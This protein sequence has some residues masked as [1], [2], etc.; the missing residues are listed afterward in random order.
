MPWIND[1]YYYTR[2]ILDAIVEWYCLLYDRQMKI[3]TYQITHLL[4]LVEF[5]ADF[6]IALDSIGRGKWRGLT[7][8]NFNNYGQFGRMQRVIIASILGITDYEL[9]AFGFSDAKQ[10]RYEGYKRMVGFLNE[11]KARI[12]P[13]PKS[14][15]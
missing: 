9:R 13:C 11:N 10:L 8:H 6:D 2:G 4:T 5:K 7:S 3:G 12:L 15:S 14:Q 1:E